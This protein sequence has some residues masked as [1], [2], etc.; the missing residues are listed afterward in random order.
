MARVLTNAMLLQEAEAT[1]IKKLNQEYCSMFLEQMARL[2]VW[3]L[4]EVGYTY[5]K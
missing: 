4:E 5:A 2:T 1:H 3:G